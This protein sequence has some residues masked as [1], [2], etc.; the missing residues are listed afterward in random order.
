MVHEDA[1]TRARCGRV[2]ESQVA[3]ERPETVVRSSKGDMYTLC[4]TAPSTTAT[5]SSLL[6]LWC[7]PLTSLRHL[8][9][10]RRQAQVPVYQKTNARLLD[11][12]TGQRRRYGKRAGPAAPKPFMSFTTFALTAFVGYKAVATLWRLVK[13]RRQQQQQDH[14]LDVSEEEEGHWQQQQQQQQRALP[15]TQVGLHRGHGFTPGGVSRLQPYSCLRQPLPAHGPWPTLPSQKVGAVFHGPH[16]PC[17]P[18]LLFPPTPCLTFPPPS[19][20]TLPPSPPAT[21]CV[22]HPA[23]A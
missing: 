4:V 8:R 16:I 22:L 14:L 10:P 11:P 18:P 15:S 9:R 3:F 5:S 19:T 7:R 23:A 6:Q 2:T 12:A 1:A 20:H 21:L 17:P 13:G